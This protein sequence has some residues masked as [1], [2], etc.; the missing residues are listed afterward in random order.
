MS[1]RT[2]IIF[3]AEVHDKPPKKNYITN[4]TTVYNFDDTWSFDKRDLGGYGSQSSRGHRYVLI[5]VD[6]FS[7]AG[8][9]AP[10]EKNLKQ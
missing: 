9:T 10:S 8:G 3:I 7:K 2:N 1:K 4:K 6:N 5:V